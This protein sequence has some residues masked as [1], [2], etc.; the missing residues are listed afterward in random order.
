MNIDRQKPEAQKTHECII[1]CR[2]HIDITGVKEVTSFD[3]G[4]VMLVTDCGDMTLEGEGLRVG[5]LD[6]DKGIISVDG[7]I[8]AVYYSE[9]V[10]KSR[11]GL[12]SRDKD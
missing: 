11:K 4:A 3:D 2:K 10:R 7:I 9:S 6:T 1:K 12:F 5:V 8:S